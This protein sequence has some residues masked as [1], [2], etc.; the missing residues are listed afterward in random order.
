MSDTNEKGNTALHVT[1][2]HG[3]TDLIDAEYPCQVLWRP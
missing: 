2:Y 3:Q 1:A